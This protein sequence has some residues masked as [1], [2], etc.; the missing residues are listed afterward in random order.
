[1]LGTAKPAAISF[2]SELNEKIAYYK[3]TVAIR[4][5]RSA[6]GTKTTASTTT[7]TK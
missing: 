3:N 1:V 2:V 6:K 7:T 5:G 4:E